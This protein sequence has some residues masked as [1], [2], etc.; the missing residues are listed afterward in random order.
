MHSSSIKGSERQKK[1]GM[2]SIVWWG[3]DRVGQGV[4]KGWGGGLQAS[5]GLTTVLEI[6]RV[7]CDQPLNMQRTPAACVQTFVCRFRTG[8]SLKTTAA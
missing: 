5:R 1:E 3:E 2:S 7:L 6:Q 4:G 8:N